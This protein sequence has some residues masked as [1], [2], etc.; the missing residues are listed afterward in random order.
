MNSWFKFSNSIQNQQTQERSPRFHLKNFRFVAFLINKK[1][2]KWVPKNTD[3]WSDLT[4]NPCS[5]HSTLFPTNIKGC[6][7]SWAVQWWHWN[8]KMGLWSHAMI[9]FSTTVLPSSQMLK[10]FTMS[11]QMS[12]LVTQNFSPSNRPKICHKKCSKKKSLK[13]PKLI[14]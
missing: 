9:V 12:F 7:L 11:L 3:L 10:E 5:T 6:Q 8:T 14:F 13:L 1:K 2:I 4:E